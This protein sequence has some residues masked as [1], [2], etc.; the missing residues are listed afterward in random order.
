MIFKYC[1]DHE[2]PLVDLTDLGRLLNYLTRDLGK[3]YME[4]YGGMATATVGV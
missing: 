1:D 4:A 3:T 2:L